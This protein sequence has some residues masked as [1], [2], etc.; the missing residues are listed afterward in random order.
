MDISKLKILNYS[1][2][3]NQE[4][5]DLVLVFYGGVYV[6]EVWVTNLKFKKIYLFLLLYHF[7]NYL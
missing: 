3:I 4:C 1:A 2:I 6:I 7:L 5:Y